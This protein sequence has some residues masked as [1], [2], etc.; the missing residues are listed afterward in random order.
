MRAVRG[1]LLV[2][3]LVASLAFNC[4]ALAIHLTAE[5]PWR[6]APIQQQ[7]LVN[8][9][10]AAR[11]AE[12]IPG[13]TAEDEHREGRTASQSS[14]STHGGIWGWFG[15]VAWVIYGAVIGL[16]RM[17][18]LLAPC[19]LSSALWLTRYLRVTAR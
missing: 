10:D 7:P 8:E 2:A 11:P 16:L 18:L 14:A 4:V 5:R 12:K 15:V 3:A 6:T 13:S 19:A 1:S 17:S 9:T